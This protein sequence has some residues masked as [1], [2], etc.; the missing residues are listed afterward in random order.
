MATKEWLTNSFA[1]YNPK[2]VIYEFRTMEV[3]SGGKWKY[4][5]SELIKR[6]AQQYVYSAGD[7]V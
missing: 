6:T 3:K 2:L 1:R 7:D 4:K 5:S